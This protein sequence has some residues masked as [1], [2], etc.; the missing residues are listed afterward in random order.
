MFIIAPRGASGFGADG[1]YEKLNYQTPY[2]AT[3][4]GFIGI[5]D[6]TFVEVKN[7]EDSGQKLTN[8]IARVRNQIAQ[9]VK[10]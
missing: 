9:V 8:A 2:L 10:R 6:I 4:L 1:Q 3:I 7:D 5:T